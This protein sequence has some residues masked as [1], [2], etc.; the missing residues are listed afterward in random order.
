MRDVPKQSFLKNVKLLA[1]ARLNSLCE[2]VA[3]ATGVIASI[4][5]SY[6]ILRKGCC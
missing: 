3:T 5:I 6:M 1:G 4:R 2:R